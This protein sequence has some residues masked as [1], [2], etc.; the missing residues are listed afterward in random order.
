MR[1]QVPGHAITASEA[2][3]VVCGGHGYT[4]IALM[5]MQ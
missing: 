5:A 2:S 3:D 4:Q 1:I